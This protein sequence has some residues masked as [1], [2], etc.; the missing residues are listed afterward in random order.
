[1]ENL[2]DMVDADK[3]GK[4]DVNELKT[5]FE[6]GTTTTR[7]KLACIQTWLTCLLDDRFVHVLS[8]V[9]DSG[10]RD[11]IT[12]LNLVES[13]E[14]LKAMMGAPM[15]GEWLDRALVKAVPVTKLKM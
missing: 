8:T 15:L 11:H 1:M 10:T 5:L 3:N 4:L 9:Q 14:Q 13:L 12:K 2:V 7:R 6:E